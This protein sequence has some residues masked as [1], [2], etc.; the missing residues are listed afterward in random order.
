MVA[1]DPLAVYRRNQITTVTAERRVLLLY[2]G[3][4]RHMSQGAAAIERRDI[5]ATSDHLG[6]A[7]EIVGTLLSSLDREAGGDVAANLAALYNYIL[8]LMARANV[9]K[10]AR[11]LKEAAYLL[12]EIRDGW[13][14]ALVAGKRSPEQAG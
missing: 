10:D 7:Q 12:G 6:R 14:E 1:A 5:Q 11:P 2:N 4:L 9:E 8:R 13:Q 3:A